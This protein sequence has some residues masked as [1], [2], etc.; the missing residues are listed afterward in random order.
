MPSWIGWWSNC[1]SLCPNWLPCWKMPSPSTPTVLLRTSSSPT[2]PLD[3]SK[4]FSM[5]HRLPASLTSSAET[6][7]PP[8]P[9]HT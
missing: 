1:G 5:P 2:S 8:E 9:K 6:A 7:P 3:S 4:H